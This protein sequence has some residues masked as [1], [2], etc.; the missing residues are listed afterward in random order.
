M[1]DERPNVTSSKES[2]STFKRGHHVF[3]SL[4]LKMLVVE[5]GFKTK[6]F[7]LI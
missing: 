4:N 2:V 1:Q 3:E 7:L 6:I 5:G